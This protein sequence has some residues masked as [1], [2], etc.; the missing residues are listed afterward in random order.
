MP[1]D[2][3]PVSNNASR[4]PHLPLALAALAL[5]LA[6]IGAFGPAERLQ[7]QYSWP[8]RELPTT[9]PASLWFTPLLLVR[10][11]PRW[12]SVNLPCSL[13]KKLLGA[14]EPLTVLATA[15]E[16]QRTEGLLV[17][18]R[19]AELTISIG[20][21]S[22]HRLELERPR[23]SRDGT[24][25]AYRL[26]L[27]E[28]RWSLEGGPGRLSETGTLEAMPRVNGLFSTL[29]LSSEGA[30]SIE[31][32]TTVHTT[33]TSTQQKTAWIAGVVTALAALML[34]SKDGWRRR[35]R[36]RVGVVHA[37]SS[38]LRIV[39]VI[40]GVLLGVW[41]VLSPVFYDDG[42]VLAR[43]R[44]FQESGGFSAYYTS[45]GVNLPL[46]Y[47]LE[48]LE[49]WL[50]QTT[51]SVLVLRLPA[52]VCLAA[53]WV[54]CR[55]ILQRV[56]S[57]VDAGS[58]F[59][60]WALGSAFAVAAMAWGMTLRPE[61]VLAL[62][63]TGVL[64]CMFRLIDRGSTTP[65]V[66]ASLLVVLALSA[67][68]AGVAA[69]APIVVA[70]PH[71]SRW[72]RPRLKVIGTIV[73]AS[74]ALLT[75]LAIVGSD[76]EQ[77][78]ADTSSLRTYGD[79]TAGWRAELSR[80]DQ[81]SQSPY[82]APLRR[83]SVALIALAVIAFL[84]RRRSH[85]SGPLLDLP[86]AALG[87]GL[88]LFL[89]TPSKWPWHFG[90]LI[91]LTAVAAGSETLRL[92]ATAQQTKRWSVRPFLV[93]AAAMLAAAWSWFPRLAWTELD[94]RT[95]DWTLE[96]ESRITLAK[97]A[98]AV[99][100]VVLGVLAVMELGHGRSIRAVP[101]R[102][103]ALT[104]PI[105]ALP[106]IAFT[107][108]VL[109][110]DSVK[111]GSWTL[112][113][114]N[115]ASLVGGAGCGLA[116]ESVVADRS[117]M[118]PLTTYAGADPTDDD[119]LPQSPLVGLSRFTLGPVPGTSSPVR[120]PWFN[121]MSD[122]TGFFLMGAP[123]PNDTLEL[124]WGRVAGRRILTLAS[125][126]VSTNVAS[127]I[128]PI[129]VPWRFY[130]AGSLPFPPAEANA[131][132]FVLRSST[133]PRTQIALTTPVTYTNVDLADVHRS[134]S[135]PPLVVPNLLLYFPCARQPRVAFGIA[136][137]PSLITGFSHTMWPIGSGTGPF[138]GVPEIF[139]VT[140]FPLT[141]STD[142]PRDLVLYAPELDLPG[143]ARADPDQ[144]IISS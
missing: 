75:T 14:R 62:L 117:S 85:R 107:V 48:W 119:S 64:A 44:N 78:R 63:V 104:A 83:E 46:D 112:A 33:R 57:S 12:L 129:T 99:P 26:A 73:A 110:T 133:F 29:D 96:L 50:F 130:P 139:Q 28:G 65:V 82:G 10:H 41:W 20:D 54:V 69:L 91:G 74:A 30:P 2:G 16:P 6:V 100:V 32:M 68:P 51:S 125:D 141:D 86:A 109:V 23:R 24:P 11:E 18:R 88:V 127:G 1:V 128:S 134:D 67:H 120:S 122:N 124:E 5:L 106:L 113:R 121:W 101:W 144:A 116:D 137:V 95:L 43:Q 3:L 22:L 90:A 102:T 108:G 138:D 17:A 38:R 105:L 60:L 72:A 70:T 45:Y 19:S 142:P 49:H 76:L 143:A 140:A 118:R 61:P 59:A 37:V 131:A 34:V 7:S 40:L 84:L 58:R 114:Q 55:W 80:Y 53:T 27:S 94:L 52:L 103:A 87:A 111:T 66:I 89:A 126:R 4:R 9:K 136:E 8:P 13:S 135:A 93:I 98:G 39:D 15:R 79:E 42:W 71:L 47:W 81:L 21:R 31:L 92:V 123:G 132:R 77:R 35:S 56:S 25:C 115:V 97:I 36:P